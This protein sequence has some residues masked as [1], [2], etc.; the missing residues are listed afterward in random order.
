MP[1]FVRPAA[2]EMPS[3]GVNDAY[4]MPSFVRSALPEVPSFAANDPYKI[5][6]FVRPAEPDAPSF[7]ANHAYDMP[8]F[9]SPAAPRVPTFVSN[10]IH[11]PSHGLAET[12]RYM[13]PAI[14][15]AWLRY[16]NSRA[17][18]LEEK[19]RRS[20]VMRPHRPPSNFLIHRKTPF[21]PRYIHKGPTHLESNRMSKKPKQ[22]PWASSGNSEGQQD[23]KT[24][25]WSAISKIIHHAHPEAVHGH[26]QV[27]KWSSKSK[28]PQ[29]ITVDG[30]R[31]ANPASERSWIHYSGDGAQKVSVQGLRTTGIN[32]SRSMIRHASKT[33]KHASKI[34]SKAG[35]VR[36]E[37]RLEDGWEQEDLAEAKAWASYLDNG[38]NSRSRRQWPTRV[39]TPIA[40][41]KTEH[42]SDSIPSWIR[43]SPNTVPGVG[44]DKVARDGKGNVYMQISMNA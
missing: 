17:D 33:S 2:S 9:I 23:S 6:T 1:S 43:H 35:G 38:P 24:V 8:S 36:E 20:I 30:A 39:L 3:F 42:K 4:R 37:Q 44:G 41:S 12:R 13:N 19:S 28:A 22:Q 25:D 21:S 14:A 32:P 26:R 31:N 16:E 29:H 7:A 11:I 34:K 5:P 40:S 27:S 18:E 15:N 10:A